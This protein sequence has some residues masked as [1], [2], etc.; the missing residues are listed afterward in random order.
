MQTAILFAL[1][2]LPALPQ[3]E[4]SVRWY[5]LRGLSSYGLTED[6]LID[7]RPHAVGLQLSM[8]EP[9]EYD[10]PLEESYADAFD[11]LEDLLELLLSGRFDIGDYSLDQRGGLLRVE[12][13]QEVHADIAARLAE[14]EAL[15]AE[16]VAVEVWRV[17]TAALPSELQATLAASTVEALLEAP[18]VLP[19]AQRQVALGRRTTL[20]QAALASA[21]YDYDVE[22]AQGAVV[23]D[24]QVTV[25]P[26]GTDFGVQVRLTT[27]GG[28]HLRAWGRHGVARRP[29]P[30][31]AIPSLAG[32][33]LELPEIASQVVYGSAQLTSGEAIVLGSGEMVFLIR[34]QRAANASAQVGPLAP[35][36]PMGML[37]MRSVRTLPVEL[38]H[39]SPSGGTLPEERDLSTWVDHGEPILDPDEVL[40]ALTE[41]RDARGLTGRIARFGDLVYAPDSEP[42]RAALRAELEVLTAALAPETAGIE[43]R[44]GALESADMRKRSLKELIDILPGRVRGS[45]RVGESLT[46]VDTVDAL[47]LMDFDVEIAQ[48]AAIADPVIGQVSLGTTLWCVP[49]RTPSGAWSVT[50]ELAHHA[51]DLENGQSYRTQRVAHWDPKPAVETDR[52]PLPIGAFKLADT[53]Q[54]PATRRMAARGTIVGEEGA[55]QLVHV[56]PEGGESPRLFVVAARFSGQR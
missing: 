22:V 45:V 19:V 55:W 39:A 44:F 28:L 51:S 4:Q 6:P 36:Q 10:V 33:T 3:S 1:A 35:L 32:A 15:A 52:V 23:V 2:S 38:G 12:G 14:L 42:L 41:L 53:L 54:L 9:A 30:V 46:L 25:V 50:Y 26:S 48:A 17:P 40:Q 18:G 7:L 43:F 49:Q 8:L 21:H 34:V 29:F 16:R 11:E 47:Y 20:A 13:T 27:D 5:D 56:G 37:T 31:H 24:P